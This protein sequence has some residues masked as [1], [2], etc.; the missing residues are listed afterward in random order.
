VNP[1]V[2][3][4]FGLVLP[5]ILFVALVGIRVGVAIVTLPAPF[6][7]VSPG[8]VRVALS[9]FVAFALGLAMPA[10]DVAPDAVAFARAAVGEAA[11][12]ALLGLTV[13]AAIAAAEVAGGLC[14]LSMGLGFAS[15]VD[16]ALGEE[17]LPT[18]RLVVLF[19]ALLFFATGGHHAVLGALG[20]SLQVAPPGQ[21][22]RIALGPAAL[23]L[24]AQSVAHGLQ[25]AAPVVATMFLVNAGIALVSRAAPQLHVFVLSMGLAAAVGLVTL[26]ASAPSLSHA[27]GAQMAR[28][29]ESLA[30]GLAR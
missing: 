3:D 22:G 21:V 1:D 27:I 12:G 30:A 2:F 15:T 14:G 13:R 9:L 4:A 8:A 7:D 29:P 26:A 10:V 25:I 24:G 11:V 5:R 6:G 17:I 18:T 19:A 23:R 28:L 20:A 16:P